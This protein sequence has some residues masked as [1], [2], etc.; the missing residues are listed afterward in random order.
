MN[1]KEIINEW[2]NGEGSD[3][4]SDLLK[5]ICV[6]LSEGIV[7]SRHGLSAEALYDADGCFYEQ[8]QDEY[9]RLYDRIEQQMMYF[10]ESSQN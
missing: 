10:K 5:E 1:Q 7:A 8:Y 4:E 6:E 2:W 9:N 3:E